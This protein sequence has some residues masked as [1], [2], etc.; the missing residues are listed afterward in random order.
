MTQKDH[1]LSHRLC[2]I[3]WSGNCFS[4]ADTNF[5]ANKKIKK[6]EWIQ[7]DDKMKEKNQTS[8]NLSVW[9]K[10]TSLLQKIISYIVY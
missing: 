8:K 7:V 9:Y 2:L 10:F 3:Y 6:E 1:A 5:F 4:S